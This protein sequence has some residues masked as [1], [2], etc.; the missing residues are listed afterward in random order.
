VS[1]T[2]YTG[3][4]GFELYGPPDVAV[5]FWRDAMQRG[6]VPAGLGARDT[7]RLEM[8]MPL[9]GHELTADR[10][11]G[12][13]GFTR[14]LAPDKEFIGA[15]AVRSAAAGAERL[16]GISLEGRRAAREGDQVA[17]PAGGGVG[18]VTSGSYG[19][20]VGHA[21]ALAYVAGEHSAPGTAVRMRTGRGE[22]AG[23]I[24]GLPFYRGGTARMSISRFLEGL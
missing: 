12:Q 24:V 11:A 18:T 23:E 22:L 20:S 3:E 4:V 15:A 6:A 14:A 21:V 2:G 7:L 9:Y 5:A 8:G 19:P 1:R 16:V 17:G 13:S 10:N